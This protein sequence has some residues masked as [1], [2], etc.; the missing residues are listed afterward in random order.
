MTGADITNVG[1]QYRQGG[2][3]VVSFKLNSE[4]T[5]IFKDFTST[6]VGQVLGI[7]LDK[8][9]IS[10]PSINTAITQ[11]QG[12]I[13]GRFTSDSANHLAD[14]L[15]YGSLPIPLKVVTSETVGPTLGQDSLNKSLVAG[16]V[17]LGAV[18]LFM[19]LYYRLP[20]L[21]ADLALLCYALITYAI[22][23]IGIPDTSLHLP[24]DPHPTGHC[25]FRLERGGGGGCKHPHLRTHQGGAASGQ[26][27]AASHRPGMEARLALH[28]RLE[29][30]Y[31][32]HLL[33]P[34]LVWQHIRSEH[35][36][37]LCSHPRHRCIGEYVHCH[38]GIPDLPAP[39]TG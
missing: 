31:A 16:M 20:G 8:T 37:R 14:L 24:G 4:G 1:V 30:L 7:V 32:D 2:D 23:R 35:R 6:H 3:Y 36:Q 17:G 22:F 11:G 12:V 19:A 27:A 10:A 9:V 39:G 21:V 28:P 25:R 33:H 18:M 13:E 15:R 5:Q 38:R 34:V 26:G 29:Y